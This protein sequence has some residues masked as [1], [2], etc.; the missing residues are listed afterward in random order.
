MDCEGGR[1][2]DE[3]QLTRDGEVLE[4]AGG[5]IGDLHLGAGGAQAFGEEAGFIGRRRRG[6]A[7]KVEDAIHFFVGAGGGGGVSSSVNLISASALNILKG[8]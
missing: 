2:F 5:Q 8:S 6:E 1:L 3:A 7:V 4:I